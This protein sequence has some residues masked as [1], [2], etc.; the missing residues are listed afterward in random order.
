MKRQI[1]KEAD[2]LHLELINVT[3]IES[4]EPGQQS[5]DFDGD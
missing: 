3:V 5:F 4:D 2:A 1:D